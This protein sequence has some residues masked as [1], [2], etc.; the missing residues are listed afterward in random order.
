[1]PE[2]IVAT[3]SLRPSSVLAN[4]RKSAAPSRETMSENMAG[5][6]EIGASVSSKRLLLAA[7]GVPSSFSP[8]FLAGARLG[9][10]AGPAAQR[11]RVPP[12]GVRGQSLVALASERVSSASQASAVLSIIAERAFLAFAGA[13]SSVQAR[14]FRTTRTRGRV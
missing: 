12:S 9:F 6:D 13:E 8:F 7:T 1:M 4:A 10:V 5:M 11:Q 2:H 3:R 14:D